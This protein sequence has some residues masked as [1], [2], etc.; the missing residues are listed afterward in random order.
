MRMFSLVR[1]LSTSRHMAL[2]FALLPLYL[3]GNFHCLG[4]CGP[5][6]FMIGQH[7]YRYFY[8]LGRL[9]SF[10]LAGMAAGEIGFLVNSFFQTYHISAAASAIFGA[11]I[12]LTGVSALGGFQL[13]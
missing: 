9:L 3:L 4:M 8:F 12:I 2:F 5:L 6:V 7:R 1:P 10:T 13:R 11:T